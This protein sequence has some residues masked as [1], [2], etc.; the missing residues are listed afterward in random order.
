M[1]E[2]IYRATAKGADWGASADALDNG[3]SCR[4]A[5]AE[6]AV[7]TPPTPPSAPSA[8]AATP[9]RRI[10]LPSTGSA[11]G[12]DWSGAKQAGQKILAARI[13]FGPKEARL[14][15]IWRPFDG[16]GRRVADVAA[17]FAGWLEGE[18]FDVAGLD[19]CFGVSREHAI[20]G[21]PRT[22][23]AAL[24]VWV[25]ENY[26]TPEAFK[27]ALG[28]ER[29]RAT[30]GAS[31][32][33][34]APTNLRMFRQTYWGLRAL[35][36]LNVPVLPW[37]P[38]G[39][40]VVVEILPAHVAKSLC[41]GCRYKGRTED[42]R[43]ERRRLL[44]AAKAACRLVVSAENEQMILSD[45]EGD[46]LDAVLAAIAAGAAKQRGFVG[47]PPDA[48]SSGEGWIYSVE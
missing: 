8:P 4:T 1:E 40:R 29:K 45:H 20:P 47:A 16:Q 12:V 34:F 3:F 41:P 9:G 26:P 15:A 32:A 39:N 31:S 38:S 43:G 25:E 24:G 35:A 7:A 13:E 10:D 42:A 21:M 33:P 30:D 2:W 48:A 36:R 23:P 6:A 37:S 44:D 17:R 5:Y 19:F 46:A 14:T 18:A 22:G 28:P 27:A 11:L